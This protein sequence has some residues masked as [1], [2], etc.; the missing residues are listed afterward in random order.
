MKNPFYVKSPTK[1]NVL[2]AIYFNV[3]PDPPFKS[4]ISETVSDP[5][6]AVGPVTPNEPEITISFLADGVVINK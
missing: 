5:V 6:R 3:A 4:G 1:W 2:P